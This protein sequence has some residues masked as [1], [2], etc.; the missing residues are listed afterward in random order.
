METPNRTIRLLAALLSTAAIAPAQN[1]NAGGRPVHNE[2][3]RL[4][5]WKSVEMPFH[6]GGLSPR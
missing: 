4:A 1:V 5:R 6:A 2:A 3:Q